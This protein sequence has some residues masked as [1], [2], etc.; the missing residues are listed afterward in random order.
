M[1]TDPGVRV[2]GLPAENWGGGDRGPRRGRARHQ[3]TRAE[4]IDDAKSKIAAYKA[5][6]PVL[7]VATVGR[8]PNGK[9]DDKRCRDEAIEAVGAR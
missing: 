7:L 8:A 9:V 4:L 1:T 2:V 5:P 3:V 6:K